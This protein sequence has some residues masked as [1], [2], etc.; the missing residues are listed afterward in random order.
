MGSIKEFYLKIFSFNLEMSKESKMRQVIAYRLY[1]KH[2]IRLAPR[3]LQS[4]YEDYKE[5]IY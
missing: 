3:K 2:Q 4:L 1:K 5:R